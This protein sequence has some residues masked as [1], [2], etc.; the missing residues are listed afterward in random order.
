MSDHSEVSVLTEPST[1][2]LSP[3]HAPPWLFGITS[4]PYGIVGAFAGTTMPFLARKA[5]INMEDI[6]WFGFATM[7]PPMLQFLYAP[8][9]DIG[10][11]RKV[12]LVLVSILGAL[13]LGGAMMMPL[14]GKVGAFMGLTVAGQLISG[15]VG[16]CNGGII[17]ASMPDAMRGK[18]AGWLNTGNLTGGAIGASVSLWMTTHNVDPRYIGLALFAMMLLPSLAALAIPEPERERREALGV[19]FTGMLKDVWGV[20][21]VR[22]GWT[23]VLLCA[24]PVGTAALLNYF[25]ALA[26]D[27][28]APENVVVFVNGAASGL[29]TAA[30]ALVGGWA[31]DRMNRRAAYLWSGALTAIVALIMRT[32]PFTPQTYTI[33]VLTYLFVAGICYAAFSAFIFEVVGDSVGKAAATQY[34]LFTAAGNFAIAYVGKLDTHYHK[35]HGVR[36]VL[37]AD[38]VQNIVGIVL[39]VA[40]F[41]LVLDRHPKV[42]AQPVAT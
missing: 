23:G 24:S 40:L 25:S 31:C 30:G 14:P 22:K 28:H 37:M 2:A 17:S 38:A 10:P 36:G 15:L 5:G 18:T 6:G 35:V 9:I 21:R 16:S 8:I 26:P 11:K 42:V 32:A 33:G 29:V 4:I 27:Y 1:T 41:W 7:I 13:C 39:L 20:V 19:V 3:K 34:T 12:W